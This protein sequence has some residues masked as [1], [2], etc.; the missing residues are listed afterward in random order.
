MTRRELMSRVG[1]AALVAGTAA[2]VTSK[3]ALADDGG[4]WQQTGQHN[5]QYSCCFEEFD[6]CE[7]TVIRITEIIKVTIV[8]YKRSDGYTKYRCH[9]E[10]QAT[11]DNDGYWINC[12]GHDYEVIRPAGEDHCY[13]PFS[14]SE[15]Y[16][17][18]VYK[19]GDERGKLTLTCKFFVNEVGKHRCQYR[20]DFKSDCRNR[21]E[22]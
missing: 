19:N 22:S 18:T 8:T 17:H 6:D 11:C 2:L 5:R 12:P 13:T 4:D 9:D 14:H 21:C 20:F 1:G 16:V 15:Q 7:G 3:S 10:P